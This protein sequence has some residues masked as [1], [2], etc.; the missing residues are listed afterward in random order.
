MRLSRATSSAAPPTD[1]WFAIKGGSL[2]KDRP[3]SIEG[4]LQKRGGSHGG[5]ANWKTRFVRLIGSTLYYM[6]SEKATSAKGHVRLLGLG[7]REA[8]HEIGRPHAICLYW[9][10]GAEPRTAFYLTA[11]SSES[12]ATWIAKLREAAAALPTALSEC[13]MQELEQRRDMCGLPSQAAA[14]DRNT[15]EAALTAHITSEARRSVQLAL[16]QPPATAAVDIGDAG[17]PS[18]RSLAAAPLNF[19]RAASSSLSSSLSKLTPF[20]RGG[21]ADGGALSTKLR[22]MVSLEKKRF[23]DN[24]FDLDL[25]YITPS[26]IAM[27]FPSAGVE[28]VY[29]NNMDQ[30]ARF[31]DCYHPAGMFRCYNLCEERVYDPAQLGGPAHQDCVRHFPFDDHNAPCL[32]LL[33]LICRDMKEWLDG[34]E[35]RVVAVHCKAGK[36]RTGV[37]ISCL[38]LYL[39]VC[40]SAEEALG[41]FAEQ[42]THNAKG[43]T[44]PSQIR[45]VRAFARLLQPHIA[46]GRQLLPSPPPTIAPPTPIVKVK[47]ILIRGCPT[48]DVGGG[49]DPYV[50]IKKVSLRTREHF[51]E[52]DGKHPRILPCTATTQCVTKLFDSRDGAAPQHYAKGE[53]AEIFYGT[54]AAAPLLIQGDVKLCFK[55][56]DHLSADDKMFECWLHSWEMAEAP[57]LTLRRSDLDRACK[58]KE[59]GKYPPN[60]ELIIQTVLATAED[61]AMAAASQK[62]GA[63]TGHGTDDCDVEKEGAVSEEDEG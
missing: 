21:S 57:A 37:V 34:A 9:P 2:P 48:F 24:G 33:G 8:D 26:I 41:F 46:S 45:Y 54:A 50:V 27:G 55:D 49:C 51:G 18:S 52:A 16:S 17:R 58:K 42:R 35:G 56:K 40:S 59:A 32:A 23:Q 63:G 60:F 3:P 22:Q 47:R 20:G 30:V 53:E 13:S 25:T 31:F 19:G 39:G 14:A 11:S 29:R 10:D 6:E 44:I 61:E 7:V 4:P 38:L 1:V 5:H 62:R 28:G 12:Q 43:V 15:L 36:G